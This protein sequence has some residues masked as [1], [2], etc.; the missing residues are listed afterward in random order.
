VAVTAAP[1]SRMC[2][3]RLRDRRALAISIAPSATSELNLLPIPINNRVSVD[4]G[5]QQAIVTY[6]LNSG[7]E[8]SLRKPLKEP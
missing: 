3:R 4:Q 5:P 7:S 6:G 8:I 1:V 2:W